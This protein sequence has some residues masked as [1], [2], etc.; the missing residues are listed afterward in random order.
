VIDCRQHISFG[1]QY[2][3]QK[4]AKNHRL[5]RNSRAFPFDKY[6]CPKITAYSHSPD[7]KLPE[8]TPPATI[9]TRM[10]VL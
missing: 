3:M 1:R 9:S 4:V 2:L 6:C 5:F 10:S 7:T 8:L